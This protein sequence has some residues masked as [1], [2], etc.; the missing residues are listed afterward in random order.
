[1]EKRLSNISA[2]I[3]IG[4]TTRNRPELLKKALKQWQALAPT[5]SVIVVVDDASDRTVEKVRGG[6]D[7]YS[8]DDN[9]GVACAKNKAIEMLV[10]H[11]CGHL[12]LADD[13][14]WPVASGWWRPYLESPE[15]HLMYQPVLLPSHWPIKE[16]TRTEDLV[17]YDKPRGCLLYVKASAVLPVVGGMSV[18]FG[19]HGGEHGNWS[20]RIHEAGLTRFRYA[21]VATDSPLFHCADEDEAGLSTVDHRENDGWKY[22][23][24]ERVPTYCEYKTRPVPVLVPRRNDHGHRD[25]L[26]RVLKEFYWG[27]LEPDYRPVE[28]HHVEGPFNRSLAVNL[29]AD[30]AGNWDVAIIADSDSWV[31]SSQLYEAVREARRTNRLVSCLTEVR[32]ISEA[33]TMGMLSSG[34]RP[35]AKPLDELELEKIRTNDLETQSVMLAITRNLWERVGGFDQGFVGWGGEDNDLWNACA[36]ATGEPLRISGPA[37]HLWHTPASRKHQ[38]ANIRRLTRKKR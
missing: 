33:E 32:E 1:M 37:Y 18:A 11:G 27:P 38:T 17:A 16:L 35:L 14:T 26:W 4:I 12:F 3:G 2:R 9:V 5:G 28:G 19:K 15:P 29:A 13:D 36:A 30:L 6:A 22:V 31:P 21:D 7:F 25:R 24:A 8:F 34:W 20:D 23:K 10:S